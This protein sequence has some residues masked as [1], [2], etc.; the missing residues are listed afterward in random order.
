MNKGFMFILSML[1]TFT[2]LFAQPVTTCVDFE[3][4]PAQLQFGQSTGLNPGDEIL[5]IEGLSVSLESIQYFNGTTGFLNAT[6]MNTA[7]GVMDGNFVFM[8][9][10]SLLLDFSA[11]DGAVQ[12]VCFD[13]TDGGGEENFSVNGSPVTITQD[14]Q[15]I[16]NLDIPGITISLSPA[17]ISL[18]SGTVCLSG[19]IESLLLGGQEFGVDNVCF[20]TSTDCGILNL[21]ADVAAC[22]GDSIFD[23]LI[24]F[25]HLSTNPNVAGFDVLA[26]GAQVGFIP[27]GESLPYLFTI[28]FPNPLS[29]GF[30]TLTLEPGAGLAD[31]FP[32]SRALFGPPVPDAGL[33]GLLVEAFDGS[34][35]PTMICEDVVNENQVN[36]HIALVDRGLCTFQAKA[37]N[38]QAAGAIGL[39][40]CNFEDELIEMVGADLEDPEIPAIMLEASDCAYLRQ[41]LQSQDVVVNL[42]PAEPSFTLTVCE[43]DN[44]DCCA[45]IVVTPECDD[46]AADD[47]ISFDELDQGVYGAG[48]GTQPGEIIYT[49]SDV[50]V[51]LVPFQS[52]FWTTTYGDLQSINTF[53]N[54]EMTTASGNYLQFESVNAAFNLTAYTQP[55]DSITLDFYYTG[56]GINSPLTVQLSSFKI[57][58]PQA[59]TLWLLV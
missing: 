49:E 53:G 13:Y 5:G 7:F 10:L 45:S 48:S 1:F 52:L 26:N 40:I 14:F 6:I 4:F 58:L 20:G 19:N 46:E 2:G 16:A 8:G 34:N 39:I 56:G 12:E 55:I 42:S 59:F 31:S 23:V 9:N 38:A 41:L 43:N 15:E 27:Q 54:P 30:G 35:D 44:P 33:N 17:D 29:D 47:C 21:E 36:G 28:G 25:D 37:L 22:Y 51:F 50:S 57:H 24:D 18:E 11:A 32:F 3:Q